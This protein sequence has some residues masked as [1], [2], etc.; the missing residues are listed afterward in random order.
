MDVSDVIAACI[1]SA[2]ANQKT[3][4]FIGKQITFLTKCSKYVPDVIVVFYLELSVICVW[5]L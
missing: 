4:M 3:A 5:E 2:I 1:I